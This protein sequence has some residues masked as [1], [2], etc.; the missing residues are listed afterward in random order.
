MKSVYDFSETIKSHFHSNSGSVLKQLPRKLVSD[1][2]CLIFPKFKIR[3][4]FFRDYL[5]A[6]K[7]FKGSQAQTPGCVGAGWL[8]GGF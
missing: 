7:H 2:L 8:E 4:K 6:S 3:C 5:K 1:W